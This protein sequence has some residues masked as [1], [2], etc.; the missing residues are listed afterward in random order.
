MLPRSVE[1]TAIS[2]H[3]AVQQNTPSL[4]YRI[5]DSEQPV[6]QREAEHASGLRVDDQFEFVR[7]YDRQIR[8]L[9]A[10]ED[11]AERCQ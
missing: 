2:G 11:A 6:R 9:R 7:L 8:G 1:P 3:N 5:R 10:L 4:D